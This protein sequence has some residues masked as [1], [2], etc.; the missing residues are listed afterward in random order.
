MESTRH[1]YRKFVFGSVAKS[2]DGLYFTLT[3][4]RYG[5]P[6]RL[7]PA[8]L[9]LARLFDGSRDAALVRKAAFDL[10][11]VEISEVELERFAN[12][13]AC[14]DLLEAG[15]QEPLPVSAQTEAEAA[16]IGWTAGPKGGGAAPSA[17]APSTIPGSLSGAG[18]PG[19]L[20]GLWGAFRGQIQPPHARVPAGLLLPLGA[21]L[22]PALLGA[23]GALVMAALFVGSLILMWIYRIDMGLSF[24]KLLTPLT[25]ILSLI[26]T[27]YLVNLLSELARA[28]AVSALTRSKP[29]FGLLLGLAL[30]PRF[31]TD[32][33]G[34]AEAADRSA[35]LRIAASAM[36]AQV[37]LMFLGVVSWL[38]FR[39]GHSLLPSLS[40]LLVLMSSVF[41][42]LQ[43][44]PLAKRDG[45]HWLVQWFQ[46]SDIREQAIYALFG[47]ARPWNET[48]KLSSG[49]L[50]V[51]GVLC[52]AYI[53]WVI[54][55]ILLFPA[56][57]AKGS[58]GI[59]GIVLVVALL[60]YTI[61]ASVRR[62]Q[63][64]R[65][66]IGAS[67]VNLAMPVRTDWIII[68]V[69]VAVLLLPYPYTP[70]G[71]FIV[72]P[73]A[74]ADIRALTPGDVREVLVKEGDTVAAGAVIA[75]VSDDE[76]RAAVAASQ[77]TIAKL[78]A[79]LAIAKQGGKAEE[80]DQ[81]RQQIAT[82]A[83]KLEFSRAEANRLAAAFK[84]KAI[85]E[86]EYQRALSVADVDEQQLIEARKHLALVS[87]PARAEQ[88]QAIDAEIAREQAQLDYHNKSL[89]NTQIKAP[90]AGRVV[91]GSLRFAVGDYLERG[92]QLATVEDASKLLVEI[93]VSE[94]DIGE[95]KVGTKAYAK[96][97]GFPDESFPGVVQ[98]IA[99]SAE[100]SEYGKVVRVTMAIEH[101]D[102]RLLPQMTG[103]AKISATS[104]PL[105]VAFTR[106]VVRFFTVE[107]WSWLP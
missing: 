4:A 44:N 19:S 72:L 96:A 20:T 90:I 49:A 69:A 13:L 45:Y 21:L 64:S 83:K 24:A 81:A 29:V 78:Q 17:A 23:L 67:P 91:S 54:T 56:E 99:P 18:L 22:N 92:R 42:Y 28:A 104:Y 70:S 52:L 2:G 84:K 80:V 75:R 88:I 95:I 3:G 8:E 27:A 74:K 47:Y 57:W 106:P 31:H 79:Q 85:S 35:R 107:L 101:P 61:Y 41:L 25:M 33:G 48:R 87:S 63:A 30:I 12:D 46:T 15:T 102:G 37:V 77:A 39:N 55:W 32:T 66:S 82:A 93:R 40:V 94:N 38:M 73:N 5:R 100:R 103:Y 105:L 60:L 7:E 26:G 59:A 34:A 86:Q 43:I 71:E 68:A 62:S 11:R 6:I 53:V 76:E 98:E 14:Y 89:E 58:F 16:N 10:L 9:E 97:W 36:A 1:P 51:Y 65:G 50:Q